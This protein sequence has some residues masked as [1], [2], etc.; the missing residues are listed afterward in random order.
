L[1]VLAEAVV[2]TTSALTLLMPAATVCLA[3]MTGATDW[4]AG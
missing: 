4:I 1:T 3:W 2:A